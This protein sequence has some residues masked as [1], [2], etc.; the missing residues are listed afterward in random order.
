MLSQDRVLEYVKTNLGHPFTFIELTDEQ[1]MNYIT[2]FTLRE[3][4]QYFPQKVKISL[5]LSTAITPPNIPN[6]FYLEEKDGLEI[7]NVVNV[8]FPSSNLLVHGHQPLGPLSHGDIREWALSTA[9]AMD[10]K[11][12]SSFDYTFEFTHPNLLRISPIPTLGNSIVTVEYER[13][14]PEDLSGIPNEFQVLFSEMALADT[15][16]YLGRIRKKY[17]DGNLTTPFGTIPI[18]AEIFDEGK[19]K[20]REITEKLIAGSLMNVSI[21]IG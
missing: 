6:E 9:M 15:M 12:F 2:T 5:N 16:I 14:Q 13:I 3:W 17:G 10:L 8:I 1:I 4:S 20:K 7:L 21:A 18:N 19:D 11:Q